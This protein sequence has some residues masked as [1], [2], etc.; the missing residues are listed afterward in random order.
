MGDDGRV[1]HGVA[2]VEMHLPGVSS[3]KGKRAL[4][5]RAKASV[6]D[7]L[8]ASVAEVGEQ[9]RWQ[10]A[11]LGVSV[12]ASTA[13]G[14]DRVLE[15]LRAVIERDPRVEV[16]GVDE[17]VDVLDADGPATPPLP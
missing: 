4:L 7:E 3:L 13:T 17:L 2:R 10:R 16:L 11:V 14:V 8:G 5:N 1:H 6:R 12:V 15:R 9:E